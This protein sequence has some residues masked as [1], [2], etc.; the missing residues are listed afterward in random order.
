MGETVAG[1]RFFSLSAITP[2][3]VFAPPVAAPTMGVVF[4]SARK[5]SK[6]LRIPEEKA[7]KLLKRRKKKGERKR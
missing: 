6:E 3:R 7:E 2:P 1:K 4:P 5:L